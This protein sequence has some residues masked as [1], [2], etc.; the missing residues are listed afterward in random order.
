MKKSLLATIFTTLFGLMAQG[1]IAPPIDT[2]FKEN[3]DLPLGP[4]SIAANYNTDSAFVTRQWND[5]NFVFTT[6]TMSFHTQLYSSD[7]IIF[8]TDDFS[9]VGNTNVRLT[10]DHICKIRFNQKAFVQM[11]RD[12]GLTWLNVN[13]INAIYKGTS[14]Q[15]VTNGWFNENS[16]PTNLMVPYWGGPTVMSTSTGTTPTNSWWAK[17]TFDV[18]AYLGA[19]DAANSQNGF[20]QCKIRFVAIPKSGTPV[21][22][23]LAGWF[24]DN[25]MVEAAP[26]EL[27]P[28]VMD[29]NTVSSY[30]KPIGARYMPT[31]DVRVRVTDNVGILSTTIYHRQYDYATST[32]GSWTNNVMSKVSGGACTANTEYYYT[33]GAIAL[34][35]TIQWYVQTNDCSCPN[36]VREPD[37]GSTPEY[38][39]FWRDDAPPAICGTTTS[40]SFPY[41]IKPLPSIEDFESGTYWVAGTGTGATGTTHRGS[42]PYLNPNNGINWVV[43]PAQTQTGFAWSIRK[44]GTATA[45]TGPSA[46]ATSGTSTGVYLYTEADQGTNQNTT[47]IKTA[48]VDLGGYACAAMK[49][50]YHMFGSQM[51]D[52]RVDIDTGSTSSQWVN[53]IALISG[54]QH[55]ASTDAWSEITVSLNDYLNDIVR[56]RFVGVRGPGV[57]SDMAIDDVEFYEPTPT[58]IALRDVFNPENGYTSYGNNEIVDLW[59]QS[60]GCLDATNIPV[61]WKREYTD[62]TGSVVTNT[63]TENIT[64]KTL[65]TGDSAYY[66]FTTGPDLSG[67]GTYKIWVYTGMPGDTINDNDTI[68]PI[69]ILHEQ[70][71][72]NFPLVMDFDGAG[73]VPGN[74]TPV[75]SGTHPYN[76]WTE[77]PDPASASFA[78]YVSEGFT[79]TVG[80]GPISDFSG[81]GGYLTT[82]GNY[83]LAP[84]SATFVSPCLDLSGMTSPVLQYRLHMYGADAGAA[85]VQW[86]E[87]GENSWSNPSS[88][89]T[90][91][92]VD[93]K[94]HWEFHE[95]DLSAE[96][97]NII[98]LRLIAQKTGAGIAAD[99]A[100]DEIHIYDKAATD[101]G[102]EWV[103]NPGTNVNLVGTPAVK[104]MKFSVRNYA[105]APVNNVPIHYTITETCGA[106]AGATLNYT[107]NYTGTINAG[108]AVVASDATNNV[109]WPTGSFS[110]DAWTGK[111]GD[112]HNWNDTIYAE[113]VGWPETAIDTGFIADFE[114]CVDGN[115]YGFWGGGDLQLFEVASMNVFGGNNGM[116]TKPNANMPGGV[117]ENIYFPRFINF[118]TIA[119]A[120]LRLTH[121]ID[122]GTGDQAYIQYLAGGSWN[123]LG[124]WDPDNIVSMNWYNTGSSS[125][126]GSWQGNMGTVVSK[127]PLSSWNLSQAPLILRGRLVAAS[128]NKPGWN[129]DKVEIYIPPQ[130]SGSVREVETVEYIP[131]PD[132]DNHLRVL[133]QNTG[134]KV[135]DSCMVE[136]STDGG[137]TWSNPEK[138]VF[139]PPMYPKSTRWYEFNQVWS[140][141]TSGAYN[142]C[143]RT[144]LP[145]SKPDNNPSDDEFCESIVIP[146]KIVMSQDSVYCN[147][148][149]DP[150][151]TPWLTFNT[152]DKTGLNSWEFGTPNQ[153]PI[154]SAHSGSNAWMTNLDGNYK[155]RDSS[156]LF[157]P[158][159]VLDSGEVYSIDFMHAFAT[160]LYHDGGNVD[161][162]FDGGLTWHT[163]G[164][165]LY[166]ATWYNTNFVTSLDI[167][168]PGWTGMSNG[169]EQASICM[170]VDTARNAILRF[171]FASDQTI[172]SPGWAID[173]F[174][175]YVSDPSCDA[176]TIGQEE[177]ETHIGVGNLFP[178]PT[179]G[180]T[181][182]PVAFQQ[183][184]ELTITIRSTTGQLI[185][186]SVEFGNE[187][188][189]V[190]EF[191]TAGWASGMY[192]V[193]TSTAQGVHTQR[194]IVE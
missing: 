192:L 54:Q 56:I 139:N 55:T 49:F 134:A 160:E 31:Q 179:N 58:D 28:P 111:T 41:V 26:C 57:K 152:F 90:V 38:Y 78:F 138:V 141:P 86:I 170:S 114:N 156:S 191:N 81:T 121:D 53:G 71:F 29:W 10:F 16:Y 88:P 8:E 129:I 176:F 178:N 187:G 171:R 162:T 77:L 1:Q 18:S 188:M 82:E 20:A 137:S 68:G 64:Y 117:T 127:W 112:T 109:A 103:D 154:L 194:L 101:V 180:D 84:T 17:E 161:I 92:Q 105:A 85:L 44:S 61:T 73:T 65:S 145:D 155:S 110:I 96:A 166:G 70:P 21:P 3:F 115:E 19:F 59:V 159:F 24:V 34:Y 123:T 98:R 22:A 40:N 15:F 13:D 183:S 91:K 45:G 95:V 149:E 185:Y 130:N 67:Y 62:L 97:G 173:D 47:E 32:W 5:T 157:S 43:S 69:N 120:E 142:V 76:D 147:D 52:L 146:D 33:F 66:S 106:N 181:R 14:P 12:G 167:Y 102:L 83:G 143:A 39:T 9:T 72:T 48:C 30:A 182:L 27:E 174:C 37:W 144:S 177:L 23:S 151:K 184:G 42:F 108:E 50:K 118:D 94:S 63:H 148:F 132:Q 89:I 126:G 163:V 172:Q 168:K 165:N 75:N 36:V 122:L 164:T 189:N 193:E 116:G 186:Q 7:S 87:S 25:L 2:V 158:V 175:F 93:E 153:A 104:T 135:L 119:G 11:S 99:I 46:D 150:T 190:F 136:F 107:F 6:G 79:P 4:D 60:S 169:W 131:V 35:D 74:N 133:I 125:S 124:Y 113:S 128:G 80:S 100:F 51:G 140:S